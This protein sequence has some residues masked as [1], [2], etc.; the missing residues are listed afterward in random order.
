MDIRDFAVWTREAAR[1]VLLRRHEAYAASLLPHQ[2]HGDMQ[3]TL[4]DLD[5]QIYE[6]DHGDQIAEID[7]L[8]RQRL[9]DMRKRRRNTQ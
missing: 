6:L 5:A 2:E 3:R 1:K 7:A 9:E 8:A 4:G